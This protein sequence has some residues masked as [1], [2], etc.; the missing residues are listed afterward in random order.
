MWRIT[1]LLHA[2]DGHGEIVVKLRKLAADGVVGQAMDCFYCLSMW[3]AVPFALLIGQSWLERALLWPALSG[4]AIGIELLM[5]RLR[6]AQ[7]APPTMVVYA[8]D[9]AQT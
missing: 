1:H 9:A 4:A 6:P 2:E 8:E 3:I 5:A 7:P